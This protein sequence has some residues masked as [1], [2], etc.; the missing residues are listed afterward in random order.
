MINR[1]GE[2]GWRDHRWSLA[3]HGW[4]AEAVSLPVDIAGHSAGRFL[5]YGPATQEPVT[6]DRLLTALALADLA[7]AALA[8]KPPAQAATAAAL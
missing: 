8:Q 7:G 1:A 2:L 5:L 3:H 4:P 6:L